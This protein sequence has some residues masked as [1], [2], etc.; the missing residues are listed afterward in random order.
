MQ[1]GR[2][3]HHCCGPGCRNSL[4]PGSAWALQNGVG[5]EA[6]EEA[7]ARR[8]CQ[9]SAC[10]NCHHRCGGVYRSVPSG[11]RVDCWVSGVVLGQV[12]LHMSPSARVSLR[13]HLCATAHLVMMCLSVCVYVCERERESTCGW[14]LRNH[15]HISSVYVDSCNA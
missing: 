12:A 11:C 9:W 1:V 6:L 7:Y 15:H 14:L 2:C 13:I 5:I 8:A 4:G 10:L 3:C